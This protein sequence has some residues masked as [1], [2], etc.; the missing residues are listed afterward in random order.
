MVVETFEPCDFQFLKINKLLSL[1]TTDLLLISANHYHT[2]IYHNR[3][4][5]F[6]DGCDLSQGVCLEKVAQM[7]K[8]SNTSGGSTEKGRPP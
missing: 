6:I 7:S 8:T 3:L 2:S 1:I 5:V 4:I